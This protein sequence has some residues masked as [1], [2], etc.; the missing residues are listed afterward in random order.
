M[1]RRNAIAPHAVAAL[2]SRRA[3]LFLL[4]LY[5]GSLLLYYG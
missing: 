5:V 1:E 2:F 4:E 3:S